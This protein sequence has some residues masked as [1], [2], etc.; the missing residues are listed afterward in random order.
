VL[1]K[2]IAWTL[3][4]RLCVEWDIK[5]CLIMHLDVSS[6]ENKTLCCQRGHAIVSA[7]CVVLALTVHYLK[8]SLLLSVLYFSIGVNSYW[9]AGPEPLPATFWTTGLAYP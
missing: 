2:L 4:Y 3:N 6:S 1:V 9:A 7:V 5:S 8:R